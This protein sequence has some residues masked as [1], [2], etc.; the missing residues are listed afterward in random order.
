[1]KDSLTKRVAQGLSAEDRSICSAKRIA[2][3]RDQSPKHGNSCSPAQ[4]QRIPSMPPPP[5][6][7][8]TSP[9]RVEGRP[10][11]GSVR[12]LGYRDWGEVRIRSAIAK[13]EKAIAVAVLSIEIAYGR[14]DSPWRASSV[15][16]YDAFMRLTIEEYEEFIR[17]IEQFPVAA[18]RLI[19]E[20]E[21]ILLR[22]MKARQFFAIPLSSVEKAT[23]DGH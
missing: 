18:D 21:A 1:M 15:S 11:R 23:N 20:Q 9:D 22:L 6:P 2:R 4:S 7:P 16:P 17:D 5:R 14:E 13:L 12:G 19:A 10:F 8:D 3:R